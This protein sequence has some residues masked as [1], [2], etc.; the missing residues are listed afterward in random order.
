MG[1]LNRFHVTPKV[2]V[3]YIPYD[4]GTMESIEHKRS[5]LDIDNPERIHEPLAGKIKPPL[6]SNTTQRNIFVPKAFHGLRNS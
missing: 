2:Q 5:K 6:L 3:T 4:K 1:S